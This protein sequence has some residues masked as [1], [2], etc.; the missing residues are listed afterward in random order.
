MLLPG[1]TLHEAVAVVLGMLGARVAIPRAW[2]RA[3]LW[4]VG[5]GLGMA[6]FDALLLVAARPGQPLMAEPP[7][8]LE[9]LAFGCVAAAWIPARHPSAA[10]AQRR[11]SGAGAR[12]MGDDHRASPAAMVDGRADGQ[13]STRSVQAVLE[14]LVAPH[15]FGCARARVLAAEAAARYPSVDVRI[16][17]LAQPESVAPPGL[18]AIPAYVLNGRLIFTGN[19][20]PGAL[21]RVLALPI[22][23][24]RA[25]R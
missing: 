20:T 22:A 3:A 2:G 13:L 17:D 5:G 24:S 4:V 23:G 7:Q 11:A 8:L 15:C 18:V 6:L 9:Y 25:P 12:D 19:P 21:D 14:V 16:V 10:L 1:V